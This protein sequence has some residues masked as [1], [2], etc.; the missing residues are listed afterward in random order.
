MSYYVEYAKVFIKSKCGYTPMIYLGDSS[1]RTERGAIAGKEW[2][3]FC[4][5]IGASEKDVYRAFQSCCHGY[6]HWK[7]GGR[8]VTDSSLMAWAKNGIRTAATVED[9]IAYNYQGSL[10]CYIW[11]FPDGKTRHTE[12]DEYIRTTEDFDS[13]ILRSSQ[14]ISELECE[15]AKEYG[16]SI[17]IGASG[18]NFIVPPVLNDNDTYFIKFKNKYYLCGAKDL[19]FDEKYQRWRISGM[20]YAADEGK[21]CEYSAEDARHLIQAI[22]YGTS[23]HPRA[24]KASS[25]N[26][27]SGGEEVRYVLKVVDG[28]RSGNYIRRVSG[29]HVWFSE[30]RSDAHVYCS[31]AS[32]NTAKEK[33]NRKVFNNP[34][35]VEV[36]GI[37]AEEKTA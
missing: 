26:R 2:S 10:H 34:F 31:K 33:L 9:I 11:A 24:V 13:W 16:R 30:F 27:N 18:D 22:R 15:G 25:R 29:I 12:L 5:L 28:Y 6:E 21:A 14:R 3:V 1:L 17:K 7:S 8:W 4:N 36:V 35:Q 20:E 32:A 23:F 37:S 19:K